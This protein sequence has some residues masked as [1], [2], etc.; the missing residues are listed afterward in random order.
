MNIVSMQDIERFAQRVYRDPNKLDPVT[1]RPL[2]LPLD[3]IQLTPYAYSLTFTA[4]AQAGVQTQPLNIQ[5]NSDFILTEIAVRPNIGAVQTATTTS[6]P[7]I[8]LLISDSGTN[9]QFTASPADVNL[10]ASVPGINRS[11]LSLPYPRL[12][13]GRS[14]LTVQASNYA[15]AAETYS[16]DVLFIGVLARIYG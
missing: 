6:E 13:T 3:L 8:R 4:L 16:F 14:S 1:G 2:P 15:P 7:F 12:L 9:E 5:A 11:G 10:Y